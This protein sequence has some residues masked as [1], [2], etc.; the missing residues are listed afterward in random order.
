MGIEHER[1]LLARARRLVDLSEIKSNA[2]SC[3]GGARHAGLDPEALA[4]LVGCAAALGAD[5]IETY[6]AGHGWTGKHPDDR[7]LLAHVAS[8]VD[9]IEE[10]AGDMARLDRQTAAALDAAR[11]DLADAHDQLTAARRQLATACALPLYRPCGGCHRRR[12]AAIEAAEEAVAA[13]QAWI[14]EC[15]IRIGMCEEIRRAMEALIQRLR[16]ALARLRAVPADLGDTYEAAYRLV[17][18]GGHLPYEG[19]WITGIPA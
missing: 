6:T 15:G 4:G 18:A 2:L 12:A 8:I 16:I 14:N 1:R 3:L 7:H 11:L 10:R 5:G 19:R 17:R 13:A 9:D